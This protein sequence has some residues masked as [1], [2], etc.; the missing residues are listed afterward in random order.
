[1]SRPEKPCFGE[2]CARYAALHERAGGSGPTRCPAGRR[3][4]TKNPFRAAEGASI[5]QDG[6]FRGMKLHEH[7]PDEDRVGIP[8]PADYFGLIAAKIV[9]GI[10]YIEDQKFI[11][12]PYVI[13]FH[14]FVPNDE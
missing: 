12:P 9:R 5:P 13:E 1:M 7:V 4:E 3:E 10:F 8:I 11:E 14:T 6:G 2:C